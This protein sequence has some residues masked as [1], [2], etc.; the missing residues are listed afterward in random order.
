MRFSV[1]T[2]STSYWYGFVRQWEISRWSHVN[3]VEVVIP[4]AKVKELA[5]IVDANSLLGALH[6]P[7][8]QCM[9]DI[10]GLTRVPLH[11]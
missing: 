9:R 11:I 2:L 4:A 3:L 5:Q 10:P 7:V 8:H 1:G 6:I